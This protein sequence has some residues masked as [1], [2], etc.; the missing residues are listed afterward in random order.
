VM[1][2]Y[3]PSYLLA[4]YDQATRKLVW[5]DLKLVMDKLGLK[6]AAAAK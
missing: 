1:P 5:D 2:T 6:G 4:N 3:H